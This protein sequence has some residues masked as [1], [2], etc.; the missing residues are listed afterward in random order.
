MNRA[1]CEEKIIKEFERIVEIYKMYNLD[2]KYLDMTYVAEDD[3]VYINAHNE[4]W[5]GG[6]DAN[7]VLVAS[8]NLT[9]GEYS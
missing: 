9:T 1:E 3:A 8:K 5:H 2:G 7:R 4:Y 6:A